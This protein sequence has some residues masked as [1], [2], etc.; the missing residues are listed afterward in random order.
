MRFSALTATLAAAASATLPS[1]DPFG[2]APSAS[3]PAV[4]ATA[5]PTAATLS[6]ADAATTLVTL[7]A[8]VATDATA[9]HPTSSVNSS[10]PAATTTAIPPLA[11]AL[12]SALA[13][14]ALLSSDSPPS[15]AVD[16]AHTAI[17]SPS[18]VHTFRAH[19]RGDS[20]QA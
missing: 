15:V 3:A 14:E 4:D 6:T 5:L 20:S 10:E 13:A 18:C 16:A 9:I 1:Q 2:H 11:S 17:H 7:V 19:R 12:A 8:T